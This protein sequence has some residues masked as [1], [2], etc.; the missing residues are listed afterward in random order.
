M[1]LDVNVDLEKKGESCQDGI[2]GAKFMFYERPN[3]R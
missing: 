1:F 2:R 3:Q